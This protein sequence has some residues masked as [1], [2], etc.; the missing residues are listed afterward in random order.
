MIDLPTYSDVEKAHKR[1]GSYIH[2]TP[3]LTSRL[4]NERAGCELFFKAEHLQRIGAFKYRGA[5]NAI[6]RLN[7]TQKSKGVATHSSGNH[8]Q[9][10]AASAAS[11]G[12]DAHIV[13]PENAPQVKVNAVRDYGATIYRCPPTQ[14][15]REAKLEQVVAQTGAAFIPPYDHPHIIAGQGTASLELIQEHPDIDILMA[16]I[17]GGGLISGT[18]IV[19]TQWNKKVIGAEPKNADD[20][21]RSFQ[22]GTLQPVVNPNTVADGLRTSLSELTFACIQQHL[23][24]II[25]VSEASIIETMRFFWER[26]KQIIEPSS[27]VPLAAVLDNPGIFAGQKV[28]MVLSGGNVDL[29]QLPWQ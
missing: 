21:N 11:F 16:P 7:E 23:E 4:I 22:S 15:D 10:V 19:G 9:A 28:G 27:A 5:T 25:T 18:G 29:D 26:T 20:A 1:I 12:I 13:M 2:H 6:L 14:A 8:A 17:G 24:Q 3:V